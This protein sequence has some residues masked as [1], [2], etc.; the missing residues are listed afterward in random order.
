MF[1]QPDLRIRLR[2]RRRTAAPAGAGPSIASMH[3]Q[4]SRD[5]ASS[6]GRNRAPIA[7]IRSPLR[8]FHYCYRFCR[9]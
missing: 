2:L 1:L 4:T 3:G 9:V 7:P 5:T 6:Q 8:G